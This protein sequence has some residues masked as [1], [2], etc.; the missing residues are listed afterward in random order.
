MHKSSGK[1]LNQ[2]EHVLFKCKS[3]LNFPLLIMNRQRGILYISSEKVN[4]NVR[5]ND[6]KTTQKLI[7]FDL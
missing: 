1:F 7:W 5:S 3:I 4:K 6:F 2:M